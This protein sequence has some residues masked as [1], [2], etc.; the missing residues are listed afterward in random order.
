MD[1]IQVLSN[2]LIES[3]EVSGKIS[4]QV[5]AINY[6]GFLDLLTDSEKKIRDQAV[7]FAEKELKPFDFYKY[8]ENAEFPTPLL[9]KLSRL[10]WV[11]ANIKEY[12][13]PGLSAV[14]LGL[15][16]MEFSK[17]STDISTFYSILLNISM[18]PIEY[19]GSKEQKQRYL[20]DMAAMK[21]IGCFAL[22]EPNA[23]SDAA[24]LQCSAR[25]VDGGWILNGEK[26]WIGNAPISDVLIIWARNTDTK[27]VNGFILEKGMKGLSVE[28]MEYKIALRSVQNGTI[29]LKDCFVSDSQRLP[30]AENF[31][32]GP[33][34]CLFLTRIIASW[35]ALGISLNAYEKCLAYVK[36]RKQFN[37]S[38]SSFQLTQERLVKMLGNVQA[39]ALMSLR[40]SQLFDQS[41]LTFGQV[42]L[43]KAQNTMRGRE[44]VSM[45]R[46]LLG[47]N[48]I[49]YDYDVAKN[50]VDMEAVHSFEGT[51]DV[52]TLI[53]GR[54]ITGFSAFKS[55]K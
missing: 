17:Y 52:N 45:A 6:Y 39:M 40:V 37:Q 50:F 27:Q 9:D 20:P 11:G 49:V 30:L 36:Q 1:R 43:L 25:K 8:Y 38:L 13:C 54:E 7:E 26:R 21:K 42:G 2:H 16:A 35:I 29:K 5:D 41:K 53:A 47:G 4:N 44:V 22:T 24:G 10:N 18:I 51:Y 14:Q 55:S 12:G 28:K 19:C 3:S 33:A 46:E 15:I 34:K 31:N 48:G 23:G 32:T